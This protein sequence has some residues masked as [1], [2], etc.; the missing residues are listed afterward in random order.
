MKKIK[1]NITTTQYNVLLTHLKGD[2]AIRSNRKDR[3]T[4]IY[5]LLFYTGLRVNET[6][7]FTDTQLLELINTRTTIVNTHKTKK[8][9]ALYISEATQKIL[10][11]QFPNLQATNT[12][13]IR[14]ERNNNELSINSVIRDT[15]SY[16]K[17][18]FGELTRITSH[19][20]RQALI[21]DMAIK[22]INASVIQ[23]FIGHSDIS[24]TLGYVK[25]STLDISNSINGIR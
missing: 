17:T 5:T 24:T 4:V 12:Y 9:R 18:V 14:S 11:K 19:S 22:G 21:T 25:P 15:N 8:E 6:T 20:F 23:H 16:L 10:Q 13:L 1:D 7:Q 2:E 3:L